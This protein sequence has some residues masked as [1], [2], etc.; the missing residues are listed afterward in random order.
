MTTFQLCGKHTHYIDYVIK[1]K[2]TGW[3]TSHLLKQLVAGGYVGGQFYLFQPVID[4]MAHIN[5][6]QSFRHA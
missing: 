6:W 4:H 5:A 3:E 2:G 1:F